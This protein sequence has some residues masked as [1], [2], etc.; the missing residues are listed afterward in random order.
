MVEIEKEI[1]NINKKIL[2][3][4]NLKNDVICYHNYGLIKKFETAKKSRL[5]YQ[6]E[7]FEK[8][9][10][11]NF[12]SKALR[13]ESNVHMAINNFI[14]EIEN[15]RIE[16]PTY[17]SNIITIKNKSEINYK[18][19]ISEKVIKDNNIKLGILTNELNIHSDLYFLFN[20]KKKKK[21]NDD[22]N[23]IKAKITNIQK[24]NEKRKE[25]NK[26][27]KLNL[28]KNKKTLILIKEDLLLFKDAGYVFNFEIDIPG[29][30]ICDKNIN[31]N[32]KSRNSKIFDIILNSQL[33]HDT[34][35]NP[36]PMCGGKGKLITTYDTEQII[37]SCCGSKTKKEVGDY[38]DEGFMDGSYV[39]KDWNSG[40]IHKSKKYKK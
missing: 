11:E 36:C 26:R 33:I 7:E 2:E 18:E 9:I 1:E 10:Q 6:R 23:N 14:I 15:L 22:I 3:L 39:V 29:V 13:E 21:L 17:L 12:S 5:K 20:F 35:M 28:I 8:D 31:Y 27:W 40:I 25:Q 34:I 16:I 30:D 38:Y 19:L 37:C 24:Q 4:E 32:D